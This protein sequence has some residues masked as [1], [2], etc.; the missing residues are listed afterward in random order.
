[1]RQGVKSIWETKTTHW[2]EVSGTNPDATKNRNGSQNECVQHT[3]QVCPT[4]RPRYKLDTTTSLRPT[5]RNIYGCYDEKKPDN[6]K[7]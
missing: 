4:H 7:I 6:E 3:H 2:G 5:A 1:M